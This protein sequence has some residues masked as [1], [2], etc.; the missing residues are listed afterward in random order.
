MALQIADGMAYL[1]CMRPKAVVH[2]DLAARNCLVTADKV[3]KISDFGMARQTYEDDVYRMEN[4]GMMPVRWLPPETLRDGTSTTQ[5]DV[6]SFGVVLWEMATLGEMPYQG[7]ENNEVLNNVKEGGTLGRPDVAGSSGG[8]G[9]GLCDD[10][11][12]Q[13]MRECWQYDAAQVD[14]QTRRP[15]FVE[16]CQRLRPAADDRFNE[17]SFFTSAEGQSALGAAEEDRAREREA[18]ERA[19]REREAAQREREQ[20]ALEQG[21][22]PAWDETV[23]LLEQR[24][25]EQGRDPAWDE[26]VRLLEQHNQSQFAVGSGTGSNGNHNGSETGGGRGFLSS[27]Q[28]NGQISSGSGNAVEM[29]QL[30]RQISA[31]PTSHSGG[32]LILAGSG[33]GGGG[34]GGGTGGGGTGTGG[35]N[36]SSASVLDR[37]SGGGGSGGTTLVARLMPNGIRRKHKSGS[38][39]STSAA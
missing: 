9:L 11:L 31:P 39:A 24:A 27:D 19:Q 25:P 34:T 28:E 35:T 8:L 14:L 22:D 23:R 4:R 18:R 2:R 33:S 29:R 6:W 7:M 36:R 10:D 3:V 21:K 16:I 1:S 32:A 5:S 13:L 30:G 20:R 38:A 12:W 26:T 37:L 17:K 15:T